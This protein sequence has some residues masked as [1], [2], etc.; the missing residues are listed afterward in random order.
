MLG[1]VSR[2]RQFGCVP[3][4]PN[5]AACIIGRTGCQLALNEWRAE[6]TWSSRLGRLWQAYLRL[7]TR[8][9][10]LLGGVVLTLQYF[11]VVPPF[12]W[13]AKRAARREMPGWQKL[14]PFERDALKHQ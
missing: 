10:T 12:A 11:I 7:A 13:L 5:D 14:P 1:I 8:I 6:V 9:A 3:T 2:A 4:L